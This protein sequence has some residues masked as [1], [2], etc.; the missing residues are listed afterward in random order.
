MDCIY[1][2]NRVK[3]KK[4]KKESNQKANEKAKEKTCFN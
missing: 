2:I 4:V 3:P 1:L